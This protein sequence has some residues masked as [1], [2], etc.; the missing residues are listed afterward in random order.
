MELVSSKH[1]LSSLEVNIHHCKKILSC[2]LKN[3]LILKVTSLQLADSPFNSQ[4]FS[5]F[6]S[7]KFAVT[8]FP[9]L[10]PL[11]ERQR[12]IV[13]A[14]CPSCVRPLVRPSVSVCVRP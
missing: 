9:F 5:K 12:A 4:D 11:A 1:T 3:F 8:R 7:N 10:V 2:I 6:E 14:L 13:M